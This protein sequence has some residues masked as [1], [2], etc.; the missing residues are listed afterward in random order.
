[1]SLASRHQFLEC[2]NFVDGNDNPEALPLFST[3]RKLGVL[4]KA[5]IEMLVSLHDQFDKLSLLP[6]LS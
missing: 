1:M 4:K 2:G 5:P 6:N 3:E